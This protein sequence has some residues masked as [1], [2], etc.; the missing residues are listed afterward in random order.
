MYHCGFSMTF[1]ARISDYLR[2]DKAETYVSKNDW[3]DNCTVVAHSYVALEGFVL[4]SKSLCASMELRFAENWNALI[5][6][7]RC[8]DTDLG[9]NGV[10][11]KGVHRVIANF[12]EHLR[13][14]MVVGPD[15]SLLEGI[16]RG[17]TRI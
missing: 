7:R 5:A 4:S 15:V 2:G 12:V 11:N 8:C 13:D 3:W 16:K 6:D 1:E 9:G 10:A 17:K 14:F